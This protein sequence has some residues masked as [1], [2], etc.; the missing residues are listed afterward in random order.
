MLEE[1]ENI[2]TNA[3][4]CGWLDITRNPHLSSSSEDSISFNKRNKKKYFVY[5]SLSAIHLCSSP[6]AKISHVIFMG[7]YNV[8]IV[9]NVPNKDVIKVMVKNTG[10]TVILK[11]ESVKDCA[12]VNTAL[13]KAILN[14]NDGKSKQITSSLEELKRPMSSVSFPGFKRDSSTSSISN[15]DRIIGRGALGWRNTSRQEDEE[16]HEDEI[17]EKLPTSQKRGNGLR[18]SKS[19]GKVELLGVGSVASDNSV[20]ASPSASRGS[21]IGLK[22]SVS[23]AQ[24]ESPQICSELGS[25]PLHL[26]REVTAEMKTAAK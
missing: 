13:K 6:L 18:I 26:P 1:E 23:Y 5:I 15:S 2:K 19:A 20:S 3:I 10:E 24:V 4:W 9:E 25:D 11:A 22:K 21:F 17:E 14:E 16:D 8:S 7:N 12:E